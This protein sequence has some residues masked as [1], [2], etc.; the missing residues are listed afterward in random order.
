MRFKV[1]NLG[2]KVN[3]VESDAIIA[4]LHAH[5]ALVD[6]ASPD[7]VIVNTCT[8]TGEA[9]KKTRKAV[10]GALRTYPEAQ[11]YVTGCAAAIDAGEFLKMDGRVH[12]ASKADV[13]EQA[14]GHVGFRADDATH[15]H[16]EAR[17][18]EGF[19]TRVGIKVQDGCDNACAY[20][21]V[22]VARGKACSRPVASCV[23]EAREL[24]AAGAREAVITGINLGSYND[25]GNDLTDL[26][27]TLRSEVPDLRLRTSSIEPLD[28]DGKFIEALAAQD[29][30]LCRHVHL[31]LQ[32]GSSRVLHNMARPYDAQTFADLVDELYVRV[33]AIS[34]STDIIVGF[35]GETDDDFAQT[36]D[37]ARRCRFSKIHVFRYS[38]RQGT[39]AAERPDQVDPHVIA[40]RAQ[41]LQQLGDELR[42]QEAKRRA[43][44][45]ERV[46]VESKGF[47]MSESYF[48]VRMRP[49]H[50]RG[51]L[52]TCTLTEPDK[53]G[54]FSV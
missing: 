12:V 46:L 53:D 33:P 49:E 32:A 43:G 35:P 30:W 6:E 37:L 21:I 36:L 47:G 44:S 23:A 22:H 42:L 8:V 27:L 7:A 29:G 25:G 17:F 5:G 9:E 10:R 45:V 4:Q 16:A 50:A 24:A 38:R 3:R 40:A 39:P 11:V 26:L 48:P 2:C 18:G 34:I 14:L 19:P 28:V 20:C 54:I 13:V 31:P 52:I 1:V 51:S 41:A 15:R